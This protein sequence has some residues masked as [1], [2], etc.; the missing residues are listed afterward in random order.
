M[1]R[2]SEF[3]GIQVHS[4]NHLT[5]LLCTGAQYCS[6]VLL[7]LGYWCAFLTCFW[8][9]VLFLWQGP[10]SP[11][12]VCFCREDAVTDDSPFSLHFIKSN[13]IALC[14]PANSSV[15]EC[16]R[17]S[18][19]RWLRTKVTEGLGDSCCRSGFLALAG[20]RALPALL[21]FPLNF[22]HQKRKALTC[23]DGHAYNMGNHASN[24]DDMVDYR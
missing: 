20:A 5:A 12:I 21:S 22:P 1:T 17:R 13:A 4:R 3:H 2:Y 24:E 11:Q 15:W 8:L 14:Q 16:T 10:S 23:A 6:G 9:V 19:R 18:S 7:S